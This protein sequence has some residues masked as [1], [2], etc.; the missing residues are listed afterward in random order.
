MPGSYSYDLRIRVMNQIEQGIPIAT[1]SKT[2]AINRDTVYEWKKL[3]AATGDVKAKSSY[4]KG[5]SHKITDWEHF[6]VFVQQHGGKTL[7][8]MAK[9]WEAPISSST[10]GRGLKKSGC[11]RKKRPTV[12]ENEPKA[13]EKLFDKT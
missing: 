4:Q 1:I 6:K 2:F 10:L 11:T 5:H 3:K 9:A 8:E 12:I 13:C 7:S